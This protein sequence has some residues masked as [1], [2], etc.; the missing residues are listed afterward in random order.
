MLI[1]LKSGLDR[2]LENSFLKIVVGLIVL[3]SGV[4]E[5][6]Q[7]FQQLGSFQLGLHHG[8]ILL[9]VMQV[10]GTLRDILAD[11]EQ[12]KETIEMDVRAES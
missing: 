1:K 2:I 7:D 6:A 12:A 3:Y 4:L 11:L 5:A 8:V 9:A 10:L